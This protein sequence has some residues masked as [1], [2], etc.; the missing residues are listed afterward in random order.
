MKPVITVLL[1]TSVLAAIAVPVAAHPHDQ[2]KIADLREKS[3]ALADKAREQGDAFIDSE[4]VTSMSEVLEALAARVDVEKGEGKGTALL[5]DGDEVVRFRGE[6]AVDDTLRVTG[7][8]Q[9]L[10]VERETL[11][12]DGQTRT[13]IV[14]EMDGGDDVKIDLPG[15]P[16]APPAPEAPLNQK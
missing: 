6:R 8:G 7:L 12:K 11:I 1:L 9:N 14:I 15:T 2:D 5:I 16:A 3:K 10:S 13:R 4:L